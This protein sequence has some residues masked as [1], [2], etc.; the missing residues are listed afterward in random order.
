M[1]GDLN[2]ITGADIMHVRFKGIK[3]PARRRGC[4]SCGG[5]RMSS[6]EF[7]REKTIIFPTGARKTFVAGEV[8]EVAETDGL[9]L[10]KQGMMLNGKKENIFELVR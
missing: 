7:Q 4:T 6:F 1:A 8:Y 9:F 2:L 10:L 3:K 5:R